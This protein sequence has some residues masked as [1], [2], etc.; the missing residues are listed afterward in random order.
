MSYPTM[1]PFSHWGHSPN[2]A[3]GLLTPPV[4]SHVVCISVE[5]VQAGTQVCWFL[6]MGLRAFSM[7]LF[8]WHFLLHMAMLG[9]TPLQLCFVDCCV[10]FILTTQPLGLATPST[11]SLLVKESLSPVFSGLKLCLLACL[12]C[13]VPFALLIPVD[14][15]A[16]IVQ[17]RV[18]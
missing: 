17:N 15:S 3:H 16:A 8:C 10:S 9:E 1:S 2:T 11:S 6:S 18:T 7:R 5:T 4:C 12:T 13:T 14:N